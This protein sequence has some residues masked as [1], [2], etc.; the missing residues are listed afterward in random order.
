VPVK[1]PEQ[2]AA[3][4]TAFEFSAGGVVLRPQEVLLVWAKDL[5]GVTVVTFPKGIVEKG[6]SSQEAALREVLEE[7]GYR[8]EIVSELPRSEYFFRRDGQLVRKTVRWFVMRPL[9]VEGEH[10]EEIERVDWVSLVEAAELLTYKSD[11]ELLRSAT[12]N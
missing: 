6:E 12:A 9:A 3:G 7:T 1:T 11:R 8:C 5:K 2:P 10:D 4:K